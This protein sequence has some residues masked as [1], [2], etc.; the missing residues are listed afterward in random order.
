[1]GIFRL[2]STSVIIALLG[3]LMINSLPGFA[4]SALSNEIMSTHERNSAYFMAMQIKSLSTTPIL[5]F[6]LVLPDEITEVTAV[7]DASQV[8]SFQKN[9]GT[10]ESKAVTSANYFKSSQTIQLFFRYGQLRVYGASL[11]L[12]FSQVSSQDALLH[13]YFFLP[14]GSKQPQLLPF[15]TDDELFAEILGQSWVVAAD[16]E[17]FTQLGFPRH[18]D[19]GFSKKSNSL[20]AGWLEND[21]VEQ[22]FHAAELS[23]TQIDGNSSQS[24]KKPGLKISEEWNWL[25]R[26]TQKLGQM[27][28]LN[29]IRLGYTN[30]PDLG[31]ANLSVR[32]IYTRMRSDS[33][34]AQFGDISTQYSPNSLGGQF[35]GADMTITLPMHLEFH[36]LGGF[37]NQTWDEWLLKPESASRYRQAVSAYRLSGQWG[38]WA[39]FGI[40]TAKANDD[41]R[42]LR[43]SAAT[44]NTVSMNGALFR[45]NSVF[46]LPL[47]IS[48]EL[49]S[50][51]VGLIVTGSPTVN[52][53]ANAII[54]NWRYSP[55]SYSI[56]AGYSQID[57]EYLGIGRSIINDQRE[58]S[59]R[60]KHSFNEDQIRLSAR[61]RTNTNNLKRQLGSTT[62]KSIPSLQVDY[63]PVSDRP[64]LV[65]SGIYSE[66]L[67][68]ISSAN[69]EV[70]AIQNS[71]TLQVSDEISAVFCSLE[72]TQDARQDAATATQERHSIWA[73]S[74]SSEWTILDAFFTYG[75]VLGRLDDEALSKAYEKTG[76]AKAGIVTS[77]WG[78]LELR[79][80]LEYTVRYRSGFGRNSMT[81]VSVPVT[82]MINPEKQQKATILYEV[83]DY[84]FSE[85]SLNYS[86]KSMAAKVSWEL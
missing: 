65:L 30:Q 24:L 56:E 31:Q 41:V 46:S 45:L 59:L 76:G 74:A 61:Y 35:I 83:R 38:G 66:T 54:A 57:P 67:R 73:G 2:R 4:V 21:L 7:L 82:I 28:F 39:E 48:S 26:G 11:V 70:I 63:T 29:S 78:W 53:G 40:F 18:I 68:K 19:S 84:L 81:V 20:F 1:M 75:Q 32:E 27:Q 44:A 86:E 43:Q 62:Y 85:K 6:S 47:S 8:I 15:V 55:K 52:T 16:M 12:P 77:C 58:Y 36:T 50:E 69:T 72:W 37:A 80:D 64:K 79:S 17:R 5:K 13:F 25:T 23:G 34:L 42:S 14:D 71:Q 60:V 51:S 22:H 33:V 49:M 9:E 3:T 10:W